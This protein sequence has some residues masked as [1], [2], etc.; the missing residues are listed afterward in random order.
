MQNNFLDELK[1]IKSKLSINEKEAKV[2]E[3]KKVREERLR[4][5]FA[6]YMKNSDIKKK[7]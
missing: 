1:S 6:E 3:D 4:N 7:F 5:E 2:V